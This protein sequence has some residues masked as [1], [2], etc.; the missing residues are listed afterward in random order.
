MVESTGGGS[1]VCLIVGAAWSGWYNESF[2]SFV[3][4]LCKISLG[5]RVLGE[6]AQ[7][8]KIGSCAILLA[9]VIERSIWNSSV[10]GECV[11]TKKDKCLLQF[12]LGY[13][14]SAHILF[15]LYLNFQKYSWWT[16]QLLFTIFTAKAFRLCSFFKFCYILIDVLQIVLTKQSF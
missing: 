3:F 12:T 4:V 13:S 16:V 6:S 10:M 15:L 14:V 5:F 8:A 2:L 7:L 9:S 11:I 1:R